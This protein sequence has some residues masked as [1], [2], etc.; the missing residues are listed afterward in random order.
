M[1]S[2]DPITLEQNTGGTIPYSFDGWA[3]ENQRYMDAA[4]EWVPIGAHGSI[5]LYYDSAENALYT[6]MGFRS[7]TGSRTGEA[8]AYRWRVRDFDK[9]DYADNTEPA[10]A[11]FTGP[12]E[13]TVAF[14]EIADGRSP[15][16]VILSAGQTTFYEP[17]YASAVTD[18]VA[19]TGVP[20]ARAGLIRRRVVY[21]GC[22]CR[23]VC[24]DRRQ[25]DRRRS[26]KRRTRR[27]PYLRRRRKELIRSRI[28]RGKIRL[29]CR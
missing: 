1:V 14:D 6:D 21:D 23:H 22:V 24:G 25:T 29:C 10:W 16:V 12:V 11:G 17:L 18:G 13:M 19:G 8:G 3:R 15:C 26:A 9:T 2:A 5:R 27:I 4:G 28:P 7:A 20:C